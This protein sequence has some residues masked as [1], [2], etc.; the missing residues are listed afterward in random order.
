MGRVV[1]T[2]CDGVGGRDKGDVCGDVRNLLIS[3]LLEFDPV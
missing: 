1:V 3:E 2:V